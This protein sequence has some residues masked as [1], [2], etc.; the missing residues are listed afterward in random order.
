MEAGYSEAEQSFW[1][2]DKAQAVNDKA[3]HSKK[4]CPY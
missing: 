1:N 4:A 3:H 2:C